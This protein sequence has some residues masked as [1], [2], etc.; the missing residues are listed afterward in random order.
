VGEHWTQ[1]GHAT[2]LSSCR[3]HP[4]L[5]T[6]PLKVRTR[7]RHAAFHPLS[8]CHFLHA[9]Q[10]R[11]W[12]PERTLGWYK[13]LSFAH[14]K[15]KRPASP[16][17]AARPLLL[18]LAESDHHPLSVLRLSRQLHLQ[19]LPLGVFFARPRVP[20]FFTS[21]ACNHALLLPSLSGKLVSAM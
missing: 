19:A 15:R 4:F 20:P 3:T 18:L 6:C 12:K 7:A 10:R 17:G 14:K 9:A 13:W 5:W 1:Q 8:E 21:Q 2:G 11:S 16:L